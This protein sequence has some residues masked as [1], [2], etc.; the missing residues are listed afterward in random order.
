MIAAL[1]SVASWHPRR[2]RTPSGMTLIEMLVAILVGGAILASTATLVSNVI[3][4]NAAAAEHLR[5]MHAI[6]ELGRLFRH[7]VHQAASVT[8]AENE[9]PSV[10]L[11]LED[12]S[13]VEYCATTT[14]VA[15]EQTLEKQSPRRESYALGAYKLLEIRRDVDNSRAV[16]L[17]F[18]RVTSHV[19]TP[20]VQGQYA[21][22]AVLPLTAGDQGGPP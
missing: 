1:R 11:Q 6:G 9:S 19:D 17:L 2:S 3:A 7:D 8:I 20:I 12:G 10:A 22:T 16:Q 4:A 5:S 21:I 14:G 15:R 13:R 18:G